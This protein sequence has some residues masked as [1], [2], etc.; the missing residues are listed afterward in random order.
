MKRREIRRRSESGAHNGAERQKETKELITGLISDMLLE[1][2]QM[3]TP[4]VLADISEK[5]GISFL[6]NGGRLTAIA[7]E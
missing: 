1:M 7:F 2:A 3:E 6:V 5:Y 4:E